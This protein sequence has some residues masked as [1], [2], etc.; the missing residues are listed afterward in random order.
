[1]GG[2]KLRYPI[3]GILALPTL[4]FG[5]AYVSAFTSPTPPAKPAPQSSVT[6]PASQPQIEKLKEPASPLPLVETSPLLIPSPSPSPSP[7]PSPTPKPTIKATT[8]PTTKPTVAPAQQ[9]APIKS[10]TTPTYTGGDKDCADFGS[11]SEAQ[12][13]FTSKGGSKTN[14]VDRLDRDRDGLACEDN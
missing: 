7:T 14:N 4:L 2:Q 6:Q 5:W 12:A 10:N 1:M 13:Y 3:F 8:K 11:H 9:I